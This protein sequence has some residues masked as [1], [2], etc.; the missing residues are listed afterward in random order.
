M[1][2]VFERADQ[3]GGLLRYGIPDFKLE[4]W[5]IDRRLAVMDAEGV[6]F[7][8]GVNVGI[9]IKANDLLEQFDLVMLTGG[10]TVP[11]D[12]PIP[13]RDLKGVYP[14]MEFL[15][16]Q[17]KRV[18]NRPVQVDHQGLPYSDGEIWATDKNVVG[19]RWWRYRF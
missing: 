19:H 14:A 9:D 4:K 6:M 12:L 13:G 1:V 2:T 5:T 8:T 17:N 10:S 16:Q 15:S 18:A 7:R 3:I 11:R